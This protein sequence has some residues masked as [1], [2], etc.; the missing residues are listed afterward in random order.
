[1][2]N[3]FKPNDFEAGFK[4][5][6]TFIY[7]HTDR[8]YFG[9]MGK[10][11]LLKIEETE[12]AINIPVVGLLIGKEWSKKRI[13]RKGFALELGYQYGKKTFGIYSPV[14][15]HYIGKKTYDEFPLIVNLRYTLYKGK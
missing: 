1:E 8:T 11:K 4:F 12:N 14:G 13:H 3:D 9:L 6:N 5:L 10:W 15:H 2:L 7:N